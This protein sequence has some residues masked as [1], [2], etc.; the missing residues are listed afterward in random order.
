MNRESTDETSEEKRAPVP[1]EECNLTHCSSAVNGKA[2]T[3]IAMNPR[4]SAVNANKK[5]RSKDRGNDSIKKKERRNIYM[6]LFSNRISK[7][8]K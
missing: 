7:G 1:K 4:K 6:I 8:V 2:A 5:K 3:W